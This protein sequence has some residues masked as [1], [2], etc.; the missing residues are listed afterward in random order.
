[1]YSIHNKGKSVVAKR[2]IRA[3]KNKIYKYIT[4]ILNDTV[5]EYNNTYDSTIEMKLAF[6]KSN[7]CLDFGIK[8]NEKDPK[9]EV[10]SHVRVFKH[11]NFCAKGCNLNWSEEVFGMKKVKRLCRGHL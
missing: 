3:L 6:V 2:F 9:F 11:K 10:G 7:T 1:M 5:H 8:N 4:S